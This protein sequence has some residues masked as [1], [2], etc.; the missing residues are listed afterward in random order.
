MG[1]GASSAAH[2]EARRRKAWSLVHS[3][4]EELTD[5][6]VAAV[7][8]R[9]AAKHGGN[10]A[11]APPQLV[12]Q[13]TFHDHGFAF[14]LPANLKDAGPG[15]SF[16]WLRPI[17]IDPQAC[18]FGADGPLAD[19]IWQGELGDCYLL[20]T[21]TVIAARVPHRIIALFPHH[22]SGNNL[23]ASGRYEVAFQRDGVWSTTEIDD[24]LPC[25]VLPNGARRPLFAAGA[26]V[27]GHAGGR[28]TAFWA[29]LVEKAYA[30]VFGAGAYV[31]LV[32]GKLGDALIDLTCGVV[33]HMHPQAQKQKPQ[34]FFEQAQAA[35]A[36]GALLA[37]SA[38]SK[39]A[40]KSGRSHGLM[41][42]HGA[43][44]RDSNP[45]PHAFRLFRP[46]R[47]RIPLPQATPSW[48]CVRCTT[49]T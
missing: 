18:L 37:T 31:G 29:P 21:M 11:T 3:I 40:L 4:H 14:Q 43:R 2:A 26:P 46:L 33:S 5:A 49:A 6:D 22:T 44:A 28:R 48:R 41:T 24:F 32:P 15:G 9:F 16:Q 7:R 42:N 47:V 30:K 17:E 39:E 20:T 34:L 27:G 25:L 38:S 8:K 23:A 36:E 1:A 45:C 10:T 12:R 13:S 35:L 19:D